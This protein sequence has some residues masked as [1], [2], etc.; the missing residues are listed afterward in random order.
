MSVTFGSN[1]LVRVTFCVL[2]Y[3]FIR[4]LDAAAAAAAA[5]VA[6]VLSSHLYLSRLF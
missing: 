6:L 4:I 5:A 2:L 3:F 1:N